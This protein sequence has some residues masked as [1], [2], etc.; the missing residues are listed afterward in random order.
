MIH[1][2]ITAEI[3]LGPGVLQEWTRQLEEYA[4]PAQEKYGGKF[5]G[6]WTF[7]SGVTN[8]VL[9]L[10]QDD[11]L[12][13]NETR[14]RS[15][16]QDPAYIAAQQEFHRGLGFWPV[17]RTT[18]EILLPVVFSPERAVEDKVYTLVIQ[19]LVPQPGLIR[20]WMELLTEHF[21]PA[22]QR[23]GGTTIGIWRVALG[24][25]NRVVLINQHANLEI[26]EKTPDR[27]ALDQGWVTA[28]EDVRERLGYWPVVQVTRDLLRPL[29]FSPLR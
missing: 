15:A 21:V 1:T 19:E 20:A 29:S 27:L 18:R 6:G 5:V 28:Q 8:R 23:E 26:V 9:L 13:A 14:A 11:S 3:A 10:Y 25:T 7:A 4:L 24:Q 16:A 17:M 12:E 2:M 22:L